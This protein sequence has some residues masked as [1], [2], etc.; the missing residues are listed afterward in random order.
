MTTEQIE[1][2]V[3]AGE[4]ETLEFKKTTGSSVSATRTLCAMLN[5]QGGNV[6]FGVDKN[7]K[8]LGQDVSDRT[9]EKLS[10]EIRQI[11]PPEFPD[12][13]RVPIGNSHEVIVVH[14]GRGTT[15]PHVYQG[16]AYRRVGNTTVKMTTEQYNKMLVE[17]MH[18][19]Q[20]W[21]NQL[22]EKYTID[23]LDKDEIQRL[24]EIAVQRGRLDNVSSREPI[25]LLHRLG[26]YENGMLYR[27]AIVLFGK[28]E[29][30]LQNYPQ[31]LLRVGRF[32]GVKI[33]DEILDNRQFRGNVFK[34]LSIAEQFLTEKLPI[35]GKFDP[36]SFER[37]DIPLYPRAAIRE[38][39]AN[40]FCHR[41]YTIGGG[42]VSVAVFSDR[43]EISN[44]GSLHFGLTPEA[45]FEPHKSHPWNPLIAQCFYL[46][47]VIESWGVGTT[48]ILELV[49]S[50]G[51]PEP[52]I[53]DSGM[54]VTVRFRRAELP[55]VSHGKFVLERRQL[56]IAKILEGANEG[57]SL[58]EI[59]DRIPIQTS[60]RQLKKT[61]QALRIK[62]LIYSKGRGPHARWYIA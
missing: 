57:F 33:T 46:R 44:T 4:S 19:N 49:S 41:D 62:K 15:V 56:M 13:R 3:K 36:D 24:V 53:E 39:L 52:E 47:G 20:R 9:I 12:I 61:L 34:L 40:A 58:R 1:S 14:V 43:I 31:C 59:Q 42:S 45:L 6:L 16:I 28:A 27:A 23:D 54:D 30:M 10:E 11:D 17:R 26:L 60:E 8:I 48:K 38:A 25:D 29:L 21:E 51:L 22:D 55:P 37:I 32:N 5:H 50:A 18:R 7:G 2:M 35:A